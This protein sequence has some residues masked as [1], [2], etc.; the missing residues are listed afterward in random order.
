MEAQKE[1]EFT[2]DDF[3]YLRKIITEMTGIIAGEDKYT[4]FYSRLARRLRKLGL[5]DFLAYRKYLQKNLES[6]SIELVN[7]ITTN[8]T[9]FFR[10]NHHFEFIKSTL[11]KD[12]INQGERKLRIWSAACSTGEEP[13]SAAISVIESIPDISQWD[14]KILATDIDSQV[15][16][17]CRTGVYH[18]SRIEGLDKM[19]LKRFFKKGSGSNQGQVKVNDEL[20]HLIT[21][22][23]LNLLHDWP[24]KEKLDLI[25]CR[26][27]VIY[28]DQDTKVSLVDRFANQLDNRSYLMMGHS[29]S[30]YQATDRFELLGQTIYQKIR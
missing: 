30:L 27:V 22:N 10:E 19:R 5:T 14:I 11:V 13:Y 18:E 1:F 16:Q 8:L 7:S 24:I 3:D 25:L 15:L 28:F 6:E 17:T 26:N 21:F 2:Q 9:A 29:E 12:K 23:Q 20:K 4:M